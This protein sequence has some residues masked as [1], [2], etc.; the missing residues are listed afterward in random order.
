MCILVTLDDA[1]GKQDKTPS[2]LKHNSS[3]D[4]LCILEKVQEGE[5]TLRT[6]EAQEA[7]EVD[8][9]D[10]GLDPQMNPDE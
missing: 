7:Q 5:Q 6:Q 8:D 4:E 3:G 2:R 9:D 10:D 1:H